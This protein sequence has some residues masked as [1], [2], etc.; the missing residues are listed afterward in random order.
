MNKTRFLAL[1][2]IVSTVAL[3]S[4]TQIQAATGDVTVYSSRKEHLIQPLFEP[5]EH[6]VMT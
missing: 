3:G 4:I 1:S 2:L 5:I 6:D